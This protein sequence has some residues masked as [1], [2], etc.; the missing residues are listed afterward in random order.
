MNNDKEIISLLADYNA[1][2]HKRTAML[3]HGIMMALSQI[4]Y[5]VGM[6]N[7]MQTLQDAYCGNHKY[8][9]EQEFPIPKKE[10]KQ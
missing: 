5:G 8:R 2:I 7:V 10:Q 6:E 4:P 3:E 9:V 1:F